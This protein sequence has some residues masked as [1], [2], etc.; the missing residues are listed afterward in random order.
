MVS[1]CIVHG[2]KNLKS[3]RLK[4]VSYFRMNWNT[5]VVGQTEGE[6]QINCQFNES[7]G[8][9][10]NQQVTLKNRKVTL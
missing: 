8:A 10:K 7:P 6:E 1:T 4:G 5:V 9:I 3:K 2:C